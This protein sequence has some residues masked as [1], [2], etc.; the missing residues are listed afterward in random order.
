MSSVYD[1]SEKG[2]LTDWDDK[3]GEGVT[4]DNSSIVHD[5]LGSYLAI[6]RNHSYKSIIQ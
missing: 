1:L 6:R 3:S 5:V 4:S 2:L